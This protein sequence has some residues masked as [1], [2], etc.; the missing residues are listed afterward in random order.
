MNQHDKIELTS[1]IADNPN[2]DAKEDLMELRPIEQPD[3]PQDPVYTE[4]ELRELEAVMGPEGGGGWLWQDDTA[5]DEPDDPMQ[6]VSA[7]HMAKVTENLWKRE[8]IEPEEI[9]EGLKN[10]IKQSG[11]V[12]VALRSVRKSIG[13]DR[14]GWHLALENELQ[15]LRDSGAIETVKHVPR[16]KQILHMKVV[17]TLKSV[18]GLTTKKKK[19]RVCVC[20][21]IFNRG[22]PQTCSIRQILI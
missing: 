20:V 8:D 7:V 18:P 6:V 16:N 2:F 1:N 5:L 3:P 17:L 11:A 4:K 9:P 10:E 21:E 22:N 15:S 12:M 13:K 19:A 14:Q